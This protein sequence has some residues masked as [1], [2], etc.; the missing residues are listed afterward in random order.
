MLII[1]LNPSTTAPLLF[2][3]TFQTALYTINYLET[4]S[5]L[6]LNLFGHLNTEFI[7]SSKKQTSKASG[8]CSFL[9]RKILIIYY[10]TEPFAKTPYFALTKPKIYRE[11]SFPLRKS[12]EFKI[13]THY[14]SPQA[15]STFL[16]IL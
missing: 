14:L 3:Y 12:S 9:I 5:S 2:R 6:E 7:C 8:L 15:V 1:S 13:R 4:V 16:P 11:F 10:I